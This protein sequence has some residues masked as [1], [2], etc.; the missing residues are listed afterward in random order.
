MKIP[1]FSALC[2]VSAFT[3]VLAQEPPAPA[4][5]VTE[6]EAA[7]TEA[8]S[9]TELPE[10]ETNSPG[11]ESAEVKDNKD[12]DGKAGAE[13]KEAGG[14]DGKNENAEADEE[15]EQSE[16]AA[17][18]MKSLH[19]MTGT[20]T[21]ADGAV[22]L[23][24]P[25]GF[26]FLSG[27][28][29]R[30]VLVELWGNPPGTAADALGLIL[31]AGMDLLS[32]GSWAV[33]V[34]FE[35]EGYVSDEDAGKTDYDDL[36]KK[37]QEGTEENNKARK[38]AGY[39]TMTL[40]GWALPPHYDHDAK[41]LHWAKDLAIEGNEEHTLNYDVRVLGRRGVISLNCLASM[42]QLDEV[43]S[44]TPELISMTKFNPGHSYAEY[45]PATDK[46]AAYGIAGLIAGS[47]IA[48]KTGIFKAIWLAVLAGKK[49][50]IIGIVALGVMIKKFLGRKQA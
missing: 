39:P 7:P 33:I 30:K 8:T 3:P 42:K 14:T 9:K 32:D 13:A 31:P 18:F 4:K 37:M 26:K 1:L 35:E 45:D 24:L 6:A 28:D 50:V 16:A 21:L 2:L 36:L 5:P 29:T 41:V 43:K 25:E 34:S 40:K 23:A 48:A 22:T 20:Q 44:H 12:Q 10:K 17:K 19:F 11:A 49:F 27:R 46:K 38:E 47:A 15:K